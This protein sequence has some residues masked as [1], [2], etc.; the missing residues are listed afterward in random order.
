[1]SKAGS[2]SSIGRVNWSERTVD[3]ESGGG[4]ACGGT[5]VGAVVRLQLE[6]LVLI[7][8]GHRSS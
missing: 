8:I 1:M 5:V 4:D 2:F 7:T 6:H 3:R